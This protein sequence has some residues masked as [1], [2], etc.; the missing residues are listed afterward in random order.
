M[1]FLQFA[2]FLPLA[3][4][5]ILSEMGSMHWRTDGQWSAPVIVMIPCGGYR[6]GLGPFHAQTFDSLA[7]HIPGV[8]VFMPST[9]S[10]AAGLLNA[11]FLSQRPTLFFYPKS[12]LNDPTQATSEGVETQFVPVVR[13]AEC[14][15]DAI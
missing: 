12:C 9:A 6:P 15:R 10:D 5:Q 13:A 3:F 4:N 2:D 8:D 11:A 7:A 1:A 14:D